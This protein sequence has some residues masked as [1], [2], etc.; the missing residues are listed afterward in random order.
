MTSIKYNIILTVL[1]ILFLFIWI[2]TG[3]LFYMDSPIGM[4][5]FIPV[6]IIIAGVSMAFLWSPH[7][8]RKAHIAM[9]VIMAVF[10]TGV[11]AL[12][13][14]M[15]YMAQNNRMTLAAPGFMILVYIAWSIVLWLAEWHTYKAVSTKAI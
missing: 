9:N 14:S 2:L 15:V 13:I 11:F 12:L 3:Y 5:L 4:L 7:C 8:S 1:G 6:P 10:T